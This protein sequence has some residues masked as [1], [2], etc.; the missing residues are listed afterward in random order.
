MLLPF[1][2]SSVHLIFATTRS[3]NMTFIFII[4]ESSRT[5]GI[6]LW[7]IHHNDVIVCNLHGRHIEKYI[8]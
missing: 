7:L 2:A 5:C 4:G 8:Y 6:T 1:F 3:N